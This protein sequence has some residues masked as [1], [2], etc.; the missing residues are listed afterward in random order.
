MREA[1][2][3]RAW[4]RVCVS[5]GLSVQV[6]TVLCV[7]LEDGI[8]TCVCWRVAV[9]CV[10]VCACFRVTSCF[11]VRVGGCLYCRA[12]AVCDAVTACIQAS[13]CCAAV[14]IGVIVCP[15]ASG[16]LAIHHDPSASLGS[17]GCWG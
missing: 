6:S 15:S 8:P 13:Q 3:S 9:L 17:A 11:S 10:T 4:V 16:S 14:C 1:T 12:V 7:R 5:P 2:D